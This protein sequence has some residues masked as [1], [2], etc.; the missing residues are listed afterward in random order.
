[1]TGGDPRG[2]S[3]FG[4]GLRPA[5]PRRAPD[6]WSTAVVRRRR[7]HGEPTH[8]GPDRLRADSGGPMK[9]GRRACDKRR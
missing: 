4:L 8:L 1:M 3:M 6:A 5:S 2:R 7:R 9:G